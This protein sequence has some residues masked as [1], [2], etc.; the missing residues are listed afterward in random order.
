MARRPALLALLLTA[1]SI[2]CAPTA[3]HMRATP[4]RPP[5]PDRWA[6]AACLRDEYPPELDSRAWA[7]VRQQDLI[8]E[9]QGLAGPSATAR[10]IGARVAFDARC[11]TWREQAPV[12]TLVSTDR[13]GQ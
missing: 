2:G 10:L 8:A 11:A 5:D 7:T 13:S 12:V 3:K 1:L 4:A 6:R 9:R